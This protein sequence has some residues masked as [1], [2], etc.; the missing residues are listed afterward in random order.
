M[1]L[2]I[3]LTALAIFAVI[4]AQPALA[5]Q[6][7][8]GTPLNTAGHSFH[9]NIGLAWGLQGNG[10]FFN[11]PGLAPLPFG[12]GNGAMFG[13]GL[14][15]GGFRLVAEQGAST[16]MSSQSPSVTVMNGGTGYFSDTTIRPFVTGLIPVVG[17]LPTAP[18]TPRIGGNPIN[19]VL[20]R[21][22][23]LEAEGRLAPPP[24]PAAKPVAEVEEKRAAAPLVLGGGAA[25]GGPSSAER[26]DLSIAEIKARKAAEA[27]RA[28]TEVA[29]YLEKAQA[30]AADGKPGVARIYYQMAARRASAD[31]QQQILAA[32]RE[33]PQ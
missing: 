6:T 15:A 19:P 7:T 18:P 32:L 24:A 31:Q 26:G 11:S 12:G 1:M 13:G 30:A 28:E 23:R 17:N 33:L 29:A 14:G 10:W 8:I 16:T 27:S 5:Q 22:A 4:G 20:Q 25:D 2:R 9:E 21:L 3:G